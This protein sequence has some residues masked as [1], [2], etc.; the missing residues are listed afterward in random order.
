M[1]DVLDVPHYNFNSFS[2]DKL[3]ETRHSILFK[4]KQSSL[5]HVSCKEDFLLKRKHRIFFFNTPFINDKSV[6]N[7]VKVDDFQLWHERLGHSNFTDVK[8]T[9]PRNSHCAKDVCE[10]CALS[11]I[12]EVSVPTETEI[13]STKPLK[14][15]Y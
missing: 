13:K 1:E 15:V 2:K 11:E 8:N 5:K 10:K 3:L 4:D 12:T 14:S 7:L 6:C 9:I